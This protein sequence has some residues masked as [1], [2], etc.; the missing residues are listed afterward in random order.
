[1]ALAQTAFR[2][3]EAAAQAKVDDATAMADDDPTA[4]AKDA[5]ARAA[6]LEAEL[7]R[8][9]DAKRMAPFYEWACA[10]FGWPVDAERLA[11]MKSSNEAEAAALQAALDEA[12]RNAGDMEVLDALFD[13]ARFHARIG[14]KDEAYT[15]ND[16][17]RDR[18]KVSSGKRVDA[19]MNKLRVALFYVDVPSAKAQLAEAKKLAETGG[20]WDRNNRLA[21]YESIFLMVNRDVKE[22]AKL[23]LGGV[24]TFT[25]TEIC[26]YHDFVFYAVVTNVLALD[27]PDLKKRVIDGPDILQIIRQIPPLYDLVASL[28]ESQYADFFKYLLDVDAKVKNDRYLQPHARFLVREL[29]VLVYTQFLDAYKSV[30][31]DAMASKFGVSVAFLDRELAHFVSC[32]RLNAKIDKV[33]QIVETN[34]PDANSAH[35]QTIIKQGDLLLNR[36]QQL[37]RS[38][39]I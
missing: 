15:A 36:I 11:K 3:G 1:M 19:V 34:R 35:Y 6:A 7:N 16:A 27:R 29:R 38:V 30:T 33:M 10:K 21:V 31:L 8:E 13:I 18:P 4:T 20:D 26:D 17:I 5:A 24:A 2:Y 37:A 25:C 22:A 23:L 9:I 14:A 12:T 39:A 28:Y 32:G